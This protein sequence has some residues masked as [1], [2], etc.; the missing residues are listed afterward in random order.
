MKTIDE[1]LNDREFRM[2]IAI[3]DRIAARTAFLAL[4]YPG[5]D[6]KMDYDKIAV[7]EADSYVARAMDERIDEMLALTEEML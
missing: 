2:C 4:R 7:H 6:I 3:Y 1:V 5:H